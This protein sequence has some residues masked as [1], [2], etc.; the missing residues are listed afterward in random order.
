MC[1][2]DRKRDVPQNSASAARLFCGLSIENHQFTDV[3]NGVAT[4]SYTHLQLGMLLA[5]QEMLE[6]KLV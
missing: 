6:E 5:A 2:R 3:L 1:I 4:V